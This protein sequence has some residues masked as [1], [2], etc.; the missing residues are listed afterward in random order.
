MTKRHPLADCENCEWN[1]KRNGF[2]DATG[3]EDA[4]VVFVGESP[5]RHEAQTG[6]P[7]TGMSGALL[8]A[9]L[10]RAGLDRSDFRLTNTVACHPPYAPGMGSV[11]PPKSVIDACAPRLEHELQGRSVAVLLGNTA[12]AA[13][14]KTNQKI[15][16]ARQG[17]PKLIEYNDAPLMAIPTFHPAACLRHSDSYPHLVK[18]ILKLKRYLNGTSISLGWEPPQYK[19][20]DDHH[21]AIAGLKQL[22][23]NYDVF[24]IDIETDVDKDQYYTHPNSMLCIGISYAPNKAVVIGENALQSQQVLKLLGQLIERRKVVCHNGKYDL[25]VLQRIGII[26]DPLLYFD[27]MLA[28]YVMDER[29]GNHGLE[30][31]STEILGAPSWKD[32]VKP[33]IKGKK[34]YANIPRDILY[35][36]NAYDVAQT[37]LLWRHFEGSMG[38]RRQLHD[39]L[40]LLSRELTYVE[41]DGVYV[42]Q[43]YLDKITH[44]YVV[45]LDDLD[46]WL[47][48]WVDN[49]RSVPQVESALKSLNLPATNTQA[50]T[51]QSLFETVEPGTEQ[52]EFLDL[53]LEARKKQKLYGTYIKG[54]KQRLVSGRVFPTYLIHGTVFGRLS[55]RNPNL[56]NVPRT[57][58][59]KEL[60]IPQSGNVFV[61]CDYSQA[62]L[63]VIA[64]LAKDKY[65]QEVF[66]DPTRDIHGEVADVLFGKGKWTKEDRVR[67]KTYVFGSIYGLE[68][69][70]ISKAYGITEAR[71]IKEQN[72]FFSLIP[73]VMQW[74]RNVH[75]QVFKDQQSLK[76]HFDRIR[77]FWLI[78]KEN[79]K[80][81]SKEALAFFPQATANDICLDSLMAIRQHFGYSERS[82]KIRLTVHDSLVVECAEEDKVEVAQDMK[83]IMEQTAAESFSDFVPFKVDAEYGYSYGQLSSTGLEED[84]TR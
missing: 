54:T 71:A 2:A 56:Q 51:L 9:V 32:E 55:C 62:E 70:T 60:F 64:C 59:I 53:L 22:I 10:A 49:S 73:E 35:K 6:I 33:Y 1:S 3:P 61:Q 46:N 11:V 77:R 23:L 74:R 28:S 31:C 12:K 44:Q 36:Y 29:P 5:G 75:K 83:R 45:D 50:A 40:C 82:P 63:R 52:Y 66:S 41:L 69:Y 17:P 67:A 38:K 27:T 16:T 13:V 84:A 80:D 15:T 48:R 58:G 43:E 21:T 79:K 7:F 42:D 57:S 72:E 47:S 30:G 18:D 14:M 78:T 8:D 76:T 26:D 39:R 19:V 68:P 37:Y 81:I 20:W 24:A 25:Q 4:K 65:L 34:S